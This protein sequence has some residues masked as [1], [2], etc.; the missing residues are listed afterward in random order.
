MVGAKTCLFVQSFP[1]RELSIFVLSI[2]VM[3]VRIIK[4]MI[5]FIAFAH[6]SNLCSS[7]IPNSKSFTRFSI[8]KICFVERHWIVETLIFYRFPIP[9]TIQNDLKLLIFLDN[10]I[11][12]QISTWIIGCISSTNVSTRN[13]LFVETVSMGICSFFFL[14]SEYWQSD[15]S[16]NAVYKTLSDCWNSLFSV[17]AGVAS[18]MLSFSDK[19]VLLLKLD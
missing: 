1:I 7:E 13:F 4:K 14:A 10:L 17:T 6:Y 12:L 8:P 3:I 19:L 5:F 18:S 9:R 11:H 16:K 15:N 2:G